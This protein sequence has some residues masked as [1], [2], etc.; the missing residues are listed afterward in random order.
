M[1][2]QLDIKGY[3]FS[4]TCF[5]LLQSQFHSDFI[6]SSL[7][8][9][10]IKKSSTDK[11]AFFPFRCICKSSCDPLLSLRHR[12]ISPKQDYQNTEFYVS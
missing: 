12:Q 5:F 1:R 4:R 11:P 3:T 2:N 9:S 6:F 8:W 7:F 10:K